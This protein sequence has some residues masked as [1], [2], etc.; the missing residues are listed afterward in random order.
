VAFF[1]FCLTIPLEKRLKH[2]IYDK[3]IIA[4]YPGAVKYCHNGNRYI[5]KGIIDILKLRTLLR[6]FVNF[7]LKKM[8]ITRKYGINSNTPL[9]YWYNS[10]AEVKKHID[11]Y[12]DQN[13][14]RLDKY[15]EL[16]ND[17]GKLYSIGNGL[18][19]IQ[20]ITLLGVMKR[21]F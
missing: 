19:K 21:Y 15:S 10:N 4:K 12:F 3:W 6:K 20:V 5:G 11:D 7:S 9:S 1:N 17:C 8:K 18:E 14:N 2:Y 13:I 16:Q